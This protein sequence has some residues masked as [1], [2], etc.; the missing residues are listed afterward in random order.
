M[1]SSWGDDMDW[2]SIFKFLH[3]TS[4]IIWLGGALT[5][6]LLGVAADR[7]KDDND[8]VGIVLKVAWAA[9]RIFVPASV[10]TLIFGLVATW[11][12][13]LWSQLWVMIGL[14]GIVAT[15]FIG[16]VIL[17]P[18]AKKVKAAHAGGSVTAESVG[19]SKEI[20]A[21]AKFDMAMLFTIVADMVLKPK[22]EHWITLAIMALVVVA[23]A[24]VFLP[25]ALK[26]TVP[27]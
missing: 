8:L 16:V 14:A 10:A 3:V 5:M 26:R 11:I 9:D 12:G 27:A 7:A 21:I 19:L 13:G 1:R 18:R 2:Y 15:I 25:R 20:L 24:A 6:V 23:A 22:P 17:T 4:A